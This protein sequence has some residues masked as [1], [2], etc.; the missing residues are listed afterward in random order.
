M[1]NCYRSSV[2]R[3]D[4]TIT[5]LNVASLESFPLS[6]FSVCSKVNDSTSVLRFGIMVVQGGSVEVRKRD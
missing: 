1:V 2:Q 5:F 4:S 3:E 6:F